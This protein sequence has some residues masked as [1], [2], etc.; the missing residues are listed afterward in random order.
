MTTS[1]PLNIL[2]M[3]GT[4]FFGLRLVALLVE[5]GHQ[6]TVATRGTTPDPF[7]DMIKR[8]KIDRTSRA[9]LEEAL[10]GQAWDVVYDQ[11]C[12][13]PGEAVDAVEVLQGQV[14][15]YIFTSSLAVY[16]QN[17]KPGLVEADFDPTTY[18]IR[19][20]T[21]EE[22]GYAEGKRLCEA[23][24]F[25]QAD[26]PVAAVRF[27]IVL[28]PDDYTKRLHNPI[29]AVK[30]GEAIPIASEET[31]MCFVS[32]AE[33]AEFLAWLAT[34]DTLG[35]FNACSNETVTP[36]ELVSWIEEATGETAKIN[37]LDEATGFSVTAI[38]DTW[39]MDTTRAQSAGFTFADLP[40]WLGL[41]INQIA[42]EG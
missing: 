37:R 1:S 30:N 25:Q 8:V 42:N 2:V 29:Q 14:G 9:S 17:K 19:M 26:F 7:G 34:S 28:G 4:R 24:F 36:R 18:P 31:E 21:M 22:L 16:D 5:H 39:T 40:I 38:Q 27:P 11:I 10:S 13:V 15:R 33:A 23:V 3:G 6:V 20:G 41:L 35:P 32:S 12:Y